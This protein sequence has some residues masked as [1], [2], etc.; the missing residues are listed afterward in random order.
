MME[1]GF[2]G[3]HMARKMARLLTLLAILAGVS[4][5]LVAVEIRDIR[6]AA[7]DTG[8]RVVI[9]LS[10]PVKH[11]AFVLDDPNRVVLDV[12]RSSLKSALPVA[13]ALITSLRAGSL[14]HNGTRLVFEVKGPVS[15]Q[16][17]TLAAS[18]DSAERL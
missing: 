18:R 2:R 1:K 5:P 9:E 6:I 12:S 11:N 7:T 13:N 17:S 16:T 4:S 10:G 3:T 15:I 8:T 14:P